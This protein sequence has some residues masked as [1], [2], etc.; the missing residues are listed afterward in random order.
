ML[1]YD[2]RGHG[3]SEVTPGDYGIDLFA[4]D[5]LRLADAEGLTRF[6]LC[7]VSV[8]GMVALA[9]AARAPSRVNRVVVSS[10]AARVAA[11][12]QGWSERQKAALRSGMEP[13]AAAMVERMFSSHF[14]DMQDPMIAVL[15]KVFETTD[16]MGYAGTVAILRDTDLSGLL[17]KVQAPTLVVAGNQDP[18]CTQDKQQALVDA[19]VNARYATL[20]CGHFPPVEQASMFGNLLRNHLDG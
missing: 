6:D 5:L 15:K 14:R 13:L 4:D 1:R 10:T 3:A 20:D 12:P 7:G 16:P 2:L 17:A 9:V 18:L 8:G 19:I 11:P